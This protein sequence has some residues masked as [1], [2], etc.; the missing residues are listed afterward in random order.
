MADAGGLAETLGGNAGAFTSINPDGRAV[1]DDDLLPIYYEAGRTQ[2]LPLPEGD[3]IGG[4]RDLNH[5][6]IVG[7]AND[8][9]VLWKQ[10]DG[11][12]MPQVLE[13]ERDDVFGL[14]HSISDYGI[15]GGAYQRGDQSPKYIGMLWRRDGSLLREFD[16]PAGAIVTHVIDELAAVATENGTAI[17][18]PRDDSLIPLGEFL[19]QID[20]IETGNASF[21]PNQPLELIDLELSGDGEQILILFKQAAELEPTQFAATIDVHALR[22]DWQHPWDRF[23]VNDD[24]EVTALDALLVINGLRSR[25]KLLPVEGTRHSPFYDVS[26]EGEITA[27][28]AL[29]VIN[30]IARRDSSG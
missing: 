7:Y 17:Y 15:I 10:V 12:W 26:G 21:E 22:A 13:H 24:G 29:Q 16:L 6:R 4:A 5:R 3:A 25:E 2:A 19:Q 27:R 28:D 14:A 23:D 9:A 30:Q 8:D 11:R 20:A 18:N 1:G